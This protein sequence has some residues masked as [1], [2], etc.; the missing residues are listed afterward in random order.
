MNE[1]SDV[2]GLVKPHFCGFQRAIRRYKREAR[3]SWGVA[4]RTENTI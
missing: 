4:R 1:A 3:D 2:W